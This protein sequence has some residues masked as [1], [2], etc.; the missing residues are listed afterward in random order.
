MNEYKRCPKCEQTKPI[1]EWGKNKSKKDGL[2]SECKACHAK[3]AADW[4]AANPDE[5]KRRS[6]EQ[7][8]KN[9]DEANAGR[10]ARYRANEDRERTNRKTYYEKTADKQRQTSREWRKNN[11]EKVREQGRK[12]RAMRAA[13]PTEPYTTKDVLERWGSLCHLCGKEIDL[14]APRATHTAGW[15]FGL[16]LDHVIPISSGGSD[17]LDNVKPAHG[18]C[19]IGKGYI[20]RKT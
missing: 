2:A 3:A 19:N 8:H 17:I 7:H 9:R 12:I 15:E 14:T 13:V 6:R 20:R 18:K 1:S 5:Q 11:P 4:R 16:Q 10:R